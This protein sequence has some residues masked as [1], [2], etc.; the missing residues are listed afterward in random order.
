MRH[1]RS[2][3]T[4]VELLVTIATIAVLAGLTLT[5]VRQ[6]MERARRAICSSRVAGLTMSTLVWCNDH[7]GF[8][9]N[10]GRNNHA[11]SGQ[12]GA[13]SG[14]DAQ[15]LEIAAY[16]DVNGT[17][18]GIRS[19]PAHCPGTPAGILYCFWGGMAADAPRRLVNLINA[20]QTHQVPGGLPAFWSDPCY[21]NDVSN[22]GNFA[23]GCG[24][25]RQW[26]S[27]T[28]G[29]PLGGNISHA[30]GSVMWADYK[31]VSTSKASFRINGSAIGSNRAIPTTAVIVS[32]DNAGNLNTG[33][34]QVAIGKIG[35]W[36]TLAGA[37]L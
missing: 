35:T 14:N 30:D 10:A 28:T 17:L 27:D 13:N 9:P 2:A 25:K 20:A 26:T 5:M 16:E 6:V 15:M 12:W 1:D 36:T 33:Y 21:V 3:F 7:N 23:N 22:T 8:L 11:N 31:P 32:I 34:W 19:R 18:K 29:I 4:F 24:H 37:G